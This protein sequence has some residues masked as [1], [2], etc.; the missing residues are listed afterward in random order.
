MEH[1][2]ILSCNLFKLQREFR[3][4]SQF[5][6]FYLCSF[7]CSNFCTTP[8][9]P[10]FDLDLG[11]R[12]DHHLRHWI[13][14]S[15]FIC[16]TYNRI[17]GTF[18]PRP[19]FEGMFTMKDT[20]K[21]FRTMVAVR[22]QE[23]FTAVPSPPDKKGVERFRFRSLVHFPVCRFPVL[24]FSHVSWFSLRVYRDHVRV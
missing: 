7:S 1:F 19:R 14:A 15:L 6:L 21:R 18:C 8:P 12:G 23:S 4:T 16:S 20:W 5:Y 17:S 11:S 24:M 9:H 3:F 22:S 2:R 13:G 10:Y